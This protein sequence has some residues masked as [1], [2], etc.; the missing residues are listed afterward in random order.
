MQKE[1]TKGKSLQPEVIHPEEQSQSEVLGKCTSATY[2]TSGEML[3]VISRLS[4][5][6]LSGK[7]VFLTTLTRQS[8]WLSGIG[9]AKELRDVKLSVVQTKIARLK[10]TISLIL[11]LLSTFLS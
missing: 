10:L 3:E 8:A 2:S 9:T 4:T 7:F 1:E 11:K 6:P 5:G